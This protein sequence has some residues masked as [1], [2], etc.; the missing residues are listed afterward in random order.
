MDSLCIPFLSIDEDWWINANL[1]QLD[2]MID[3]EDDRKTTWH[4]Y[5]ETNGKATPQVSED[6]NSIANFIEENFKI[7]INIQRDW[8]AKSVIA[9]DGVFAQAKWFVFDEF[10][11]PHLME[12]GDP[13]NFFEGY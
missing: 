10:V 13:R 5:K 4:H 7:S 8:I 12:G 3:E 2:K 6:V 9:W 11:Y 1:N